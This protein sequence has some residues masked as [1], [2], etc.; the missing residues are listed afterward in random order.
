MPLSKLL[1]FWR[2]FNLEGCG[3]AQSEAPALGEP[4]VKEAVEDVELL[5]PRSMRD[6][7]FWMEGAPKL[8]IKRPY[9]GA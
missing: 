9:D 1:N 8:P 5:D 6:W 2:Y 4:P 7:A 3:T